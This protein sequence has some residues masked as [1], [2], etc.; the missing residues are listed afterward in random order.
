M[1][2]KQLD[3]GISAL[4]WDPV[5][6]KYLRPEVGV[7]LFRSF[8]P[9]EDLLSTAKEGKGTG[10]AIEELQPGCGD[11]RSITRTNNE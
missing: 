6:A 9:K 7:G 1:G 10:M 5:S 3:Y 11:I 2:S 4:Q 8:Y